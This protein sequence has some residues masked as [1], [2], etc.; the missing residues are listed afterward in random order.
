MLFNW[1]K[2]LKDIDAWYL[3]VADVVVPLLFCVV[4]LC[5]VL[6]GVTI[7]TSLS[8]LSRSNSNVS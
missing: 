1:D 3:S 8:S 6:G 7:T 4:A 2:F 5:L